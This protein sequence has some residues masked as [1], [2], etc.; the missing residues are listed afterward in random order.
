LSQTKQE[1]YVIIA[2]LGSVAVIV[3]ANAYK[4]QFPPGRQMIAA[5][6]VFVGVAALADADPKLAGPASGLA[7]ASITLA[8]GLDFAHGLGNVKSYG[9]AVKKTA[10]TGASGSPG[11]AS[12]PFAAIDPFTGGTDYSAL[13][14]ARYAG[15]DQGV[16]FTGPGPVKA[17]GNGLVT[18][19][20]SGGSGWSGEGALLVYQLLDGPQRGRFVYVAEDFRARPGL[21]VGDRVKAGSVIGVATGSGKAPGIEVGFA[22]NAHGTAYGTTKDGKPGGP[23]PRFGIA[24]R[25]FILSL[26]GH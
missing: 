24:F 13:T 25:N 14:T 18:R 2:A 26:K 9:G 21:K 17:V 10:T 1:R 20:V 8:Q 5:G 6:I 15:A 7:F 23:T 3:G 12:A 11:A 19:L 16:D 4:R 22:Q